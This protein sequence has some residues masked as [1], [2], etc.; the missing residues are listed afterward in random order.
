MNT[1]VWM[2][3]PRPARGEANAPRKQ[4]SSQLLEP[5]AVFFVTKYFV[6]WVP[7]AVFFITKHSVIMVPIAVFFIAKYFVIRVPIAVFFVT[8]YFVRGPIA[9][10]LVTKHFVIRGPIAVFF[11]TNLAE[12]LDICPVLKSRDPV[13][14]YRL[15]CSF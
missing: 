7:I 10:F 15:I 8:K 3:Q 2:T 12:D 14:D 4:H 11:A 5:F 9:V 6:I 1:A 13:Q